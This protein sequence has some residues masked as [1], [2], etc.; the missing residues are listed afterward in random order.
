MSGYVGERARRRRRRSIFIIFLLII[1]LT[2]I[3][4][5]YSVKD[6]KKEISNE[7]TSTDDT[8]DTERLSIDEEELELFSKIK[9]QSFPLGKISK[10][11]AGIPDAR[12][13][14][15]SGAISAI[16]GKEIGRYKIKGVKGYWSEE[17]VKSNSKKLDAYK[18]P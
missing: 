15:Q 11:F 13:L 17:Y 18:Q 9:N 5:S 4:F 1:L 8:I 6:E 2:I 10:T 7:T 16:G 14:K 3:Y 12:L